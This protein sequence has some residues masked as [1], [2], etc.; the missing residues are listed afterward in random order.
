MTSV[1]PTVA[2]NVFAIVLNFRGAD[3]T[4]RCVASL[5]ESVPSPYVLVVDNGSGS[6][7]W[8]GLN[9]L[10][11]DRRGVGLTGTGANLG[12]AGG[13]Q[14]GIL[15]ALERSA[16]FVWLV[17]NDCLVY[18][19][20]LQ[21]LLREMKEHSDTAACSGVVVHRNAAR[22]HFNAGSG[23]DVVWGRIRPVALSR[24]QVQQLPR[25]YEVD[26]VAGSAWLLRASV[27]RDI[28]GLDCR[29][30]L[31]GEEPDWCFRARGAGYKTVVV[32]ESVVEAEVSA[33]LGR[34]ACEQLFFTTRN[35]TWNVR[36]QGSTWRV[37]LHH[38]LLLGYRLPRAVLGL[39]VRSN[40]R[41]IPWL[42]R[43]AWE[44]LFGSIERSEDPRAGLASRPATM[45]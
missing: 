13:M 42:L 30:F 20:S 27:I 31:T 17:N 11:G 40:V 45:A 35:M 39:L 28:G 21:P 22:I 41:C 7:E 9:R 33:T 10:L 38:L 1:M 25:R 34:F 2:N 36:R 19:G 16:E 3:M 14:W 6:D 12:Y 8:A 26:F 29:L 44:G 43:G 4:A 37:L 23:L 32:P 24:A 18:P 5:L 15:A